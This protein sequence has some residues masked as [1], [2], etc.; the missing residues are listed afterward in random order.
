MHGFA[1]IFNHIYPVVL[2]SGY[3]ETYAKTYGGMQQ[4]ATMAGIRYSNA[5]IG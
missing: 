1:L 5:V 2:M 3:R 4:W